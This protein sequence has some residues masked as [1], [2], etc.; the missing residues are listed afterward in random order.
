MS[1]KVSHDTR[2]SGIGAA[3]SE[4]LAFISTPQKISLLLVSAKYG[5]ID[6]PIRL[7][8]IQPSGLQ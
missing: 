8:R 1:L 4:W 7:S 5:Y 2:L 3:I 6:I